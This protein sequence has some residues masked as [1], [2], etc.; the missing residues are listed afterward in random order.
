MR[1]A[2]AWNSEDQHVL[3]SVHE[4]ALQQRPR[5][6]HHLG[7]QSLQLQRRP[8]LLQRQPRVAQQPLD[9][10]LLPL[11]ALPLRQTQQV[12]LVAQRLLLRLRAPVP[13]SSSGT[14][15]GAV[16]SGSPSASPARPC[17][18]PSAT[19]MPSSKASYD[20]RSTPATVTAVGDNTLS[21]RASSAATRPALSGPRASSRRTS[22]A[23]T[24]ASLCRAARYKIPRYSLAARSG[25]CAVSTS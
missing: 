5:L 17:P 1:L 12:L 10:P 24:P 14:P 25:C 22:A 21:L 7:R 20:A 9:P 15:A 2:G 6:L 4:R 13:R 11:L 23:S 3:L 19:S 8:A 18:V 16:L